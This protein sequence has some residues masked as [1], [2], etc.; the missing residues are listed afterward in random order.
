MDLKIVTP[1][2]VVVDKNKVT[3]VT[4]PTSEG[5]ITIKE[6]HVPMIL[7]LSPGEID[8]YYEDSTNEFLA[9]SKGIIEI[10][11]NSVVN[12]LA[13]TAERAEDIDILRAEEAK[14]KAEQLRERIEND[15]TIDYTA[16]SSKI[17]KELARL[18]VGKRW[19]NIKI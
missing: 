9:V 4:V 15:A 19:K 12:V 8:V 11:I 3:S 6:D 2:G 18:E 16:I 17:Q 13:D 7:L 1:D 14:N 10:Q 5:I